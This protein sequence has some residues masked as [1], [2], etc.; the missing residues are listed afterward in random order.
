[1]F[2]YQGCGSG[3]WQEFV[4][5]V[6]SGCLYSTVIS[7]NNDLRDHIICHVNGCMLVTFL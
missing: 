6:G 4:I 3:L 5:F 7:D 2:V 1:M